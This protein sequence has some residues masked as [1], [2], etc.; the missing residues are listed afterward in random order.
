MSKYCFVQPSLEYL[1]HI[2]TSEGVSADRTKIA[3]MQS[4]PVPKNLKELR[5]FL[6]LTGYYRKFVQHYGSISKPLTNLLKKNLFIW[7]SAATNAFEA[8]KLA[9]STTPSLALPDFTKTFV[10]E[11]DAS[12]LCIGDVLL[13]EGKPIAY[14]SKPLRPRARALSTYEKEFLAIVLAVQRWRHY[15]QGHKFIIR[16]DH[17][18]IQYFLNQKITTSLQQKYLIKLLGFDYEIQYKKGTANIVDDALSR[19]P[20]TEAACNAIYLSTPS[21][22]Q[23]VIHSYDQDHKAAQIISHLLLQYDS[24]PHFTY[25]EGILRYKNRLYIGTGGQI[26]HG[27]ITMDFIDGLPISNRKS[28]ILVIVE[29]LTKYAHFI[30]LQHPYTAASMA[31]EFLTNVFKLHGLPSSIVSDRDKMFTIN[32]WQDLFKSLGTELNLSTSYYPQTDGQTE[33]VN[34]CLENYLRCICGHKPSNWSQCL[35]L[36]EWWYNTSYHRGLK[37]SPFQVLYGYVPPHMAFPTTATTSVDAVESYLKERATMIE[38]LKESLGKAQERM[39]LYADISRVERSFVVGDLVYL[40]LQ[41]YRQASVSL[42]KNFKLSEKFYGPFKKVLQTRTIIIV[43][44][45]VPQVLIQLTNS[46]P[47]EATWEA[48]SNIKAHYPRFIL[49]DKDSL[50]GK[51]ML[52]SVG[53]QHTP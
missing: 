37:I 18:N 23:D 15:L 45:L 5:G 30:A 4:W 47:G 42:R 36:V 10:V 24:V 11:S 38:L 41:P 20:M 26:K 6:G 7:S 3:C 51:A 48:I 31:Q 50:Q 1:G 12:D 49:E 25:K 14:F 39:K 2:V 52:H 34:A 35:A 44:Q 13:Q 29:R 40:K 46:S 16:T 9:M 28:V 19:R 33:R 8:L 21:W 27:N 53:K 43:K 32:F 17:Q 22:V